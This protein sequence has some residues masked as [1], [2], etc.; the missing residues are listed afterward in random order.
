[1]KWPPEIRQGCIVGCGTVALVLI[2][3]ILFSI[4]S[5]MDV[6]SYIF[7]FFAAGIGSI[8]GQRLQKKAE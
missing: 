5:P 6:R 1:M 2:L 3:N 8:I 7:L 4:T